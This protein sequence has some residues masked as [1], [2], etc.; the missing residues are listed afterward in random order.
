MYKFVDKVLI[1]IYWYVDQALVKKEISVNIYMPQ[2]W[3]NWNFSLRIKK[4]N[5]CIWICLYLYYM[6]DSTSFL[7]NGYNVCILS[8]LQNVPRDIGFYQIITTVVNLV[9]FRV[10]E[11]NVEGSV[12]V[13]RRNAITYMAV[14]LHVSI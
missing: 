6:Y 9:S 8:T 7:Y 1:Q 5:K 12:I 11:R 13:Q 4:K 10:M 2:F 14:L 3:I